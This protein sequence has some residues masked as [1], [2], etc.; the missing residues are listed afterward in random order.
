MPSTAADHGTAAEKGVLTMAMPSERIWPIVLAAGNGRRLSGLTG[1]GN[2]AG[3][4]KQFWRIDGETTMFRWTLGR[5]ARLAPTD[6]TIAVVSQDHR[7]WW[8]EEAVDLPRENVVAQPANRGTASGILLPLLHVYRR[9]PE[10][11]VVILPSDHY[12]EDEE[13]L[14]RSLCGAVRAVAQEPESVVLL[15]ITP[16]IPDPEYGWILPSV[17]GGESS[18]PVAAFIEKPNVMTARV[19]LRDG[20]LWNS[21][22]FAARARALLDLFQHTRPDLTEMFDL[23]FR[24]GAP[25][26]V[27]ANGTSGSAAL[28]ALY[29]ALPDADFSRDVLQGAAHQLRVVA[30][31]PCGWT[32]LGTPLRV[33]RWREAREART[34]TTR[35]SLLNAL[36]LVE[37]VQAGDFVGLG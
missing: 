27:G 35:R 36:D 13:V 3:V 5:A 18:R 1:N 19:L 2:G 15:G 34:P 28:R 9:D 16:E 11:T 12:V 26:A 30:V 7:A 29:D 32:D 17:A 24:G 4:P 23:A 33:A 21:F 31:P 25:G 6:R 22:V 20:A 10:A 14:V 37:P 8:E